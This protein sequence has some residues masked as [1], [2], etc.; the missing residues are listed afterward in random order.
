M[1]GKTQKKRKKE[2]EPIRT[3]SADEFFALKD[4]GLIR[5]KIE[6]EIKFRSPVTITIHS[7]LG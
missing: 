3:W 4:A 6:R 7:F 2:H 5:T 1:A